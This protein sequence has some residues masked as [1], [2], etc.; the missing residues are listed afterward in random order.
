MTAIGVTTLGLSAFFTT[1]TAS[2]MS[3]WHPKWLLGTF[4]TGFV[5]GVIFG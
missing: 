5:L 3:D 4:L 1:K 2:L